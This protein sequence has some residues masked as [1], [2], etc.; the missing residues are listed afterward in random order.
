[1]GAVLLS[2]KQARSYFKDLDADSKLGEVM[3]KFTCGASL[4]FINRVSRK[5]LG[6]ATDQNRPNNKITDNM[7]SD[8]TSALM[9]LTLVNMSKC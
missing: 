8:F 9:F 4:K 7:W 6:Q 5:N 1:M 2:G 3:P